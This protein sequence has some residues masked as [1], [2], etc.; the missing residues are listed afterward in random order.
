[1]SI[2]LA[3]AKVL[4]QRVGVVL[5]W[6]SRFNFDDYHAYVVALGDA[7]TRT[8]EVLGFRNRYARLG[9]HFHHDDE[10]QRHACG[11]PIDARE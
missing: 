1:M 10:L 9:A 7:V 6:P 5:I 8:G 2:S 4:A 11:S 3:N